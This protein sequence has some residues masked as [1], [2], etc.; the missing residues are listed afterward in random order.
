MIDIL[1]WPIRFLHRLVLRAIVFLAIGQVWANKFRSFLTSLGIIIGVLGVGRWLPPGSTACR[2]IVLNQF[3]DLRRQEDVDLGQCARE[4][5][6]RHELDRRQ[7]VHIRSPPPP[8]Q[9]TAGR[10]TTLTPTCNSNWSVSFGKE[11]LQGVN[12]TGI[13]PEWHEIEDRQ[14]VYGRPFSKIDDQENRQVCLINEQ[15]IE[16]LNL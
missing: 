15:G 13:W 12:V 6:L 9:G 2:A 10:R 16:E 11:N 7:N 8:R 1:L 3:E 5:A 4:Q 14:V